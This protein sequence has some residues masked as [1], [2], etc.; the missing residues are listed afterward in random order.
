[1]SN[2]SFYKVIIFIIYL[3]IP[4]SGIAKDYSPVIIYYPRNEYH[5]KSQ[6]WSVVTDKK[7]NI[8]FGNNDGLLEFDGF[9]WKLHKYPNTVNTRSLYYDAETDRIYSGH[10]EEVGFWERD[11]YGNLSYNS[12]KEQFDQEFLTNNSFWS[13]T[14]QDSIVYFQSFAAI[15][16]YNESTK[17][18]KLLAQQG[19]FLFLGKANKKIYSKSSDLGLITIKNESFNRMGSVD[20]VSNSTLRFYLDHHDGTLIGSAENG[21]FILKDDKIKEW[22]AESN[23]LL[24]TQNINCGVKLNNGDYAIGSISGGLFILDK[25]G[26]IL[27]Q[28]NQHNGLE[29]N[30]VLSIA[31]DQQDNLWLGLD[32]GIAHIIVNS[33][34]HYRV[35]KKNIPYSIYSVIEHKG[36]CYLA[37]NTGLLFAKAKS[38]KHLNF[39][40]LKLMPGINEHI[41]KLDVIE[42]ELLCGCNN[43][44]Y[45]IRN[46]KAVS[47]S[48]KSGVTDFSLTWHN[49][50]KY[51]VASTYNDLYVFQLNNKEWEFAH[52]VKGF[53]GTCRLIEIDNYG[54]VW[55]SHEVKGLTRLKLD[56]SYSE[57]LSSKSFGTDDGLP[58]DYHLDIFNANQHIV[59]STDI[60]LYTFD[61]IQNKIV[62]FKKLNRILSSS[63]RINNIISEGNNHLWVVGDRQISLVQSD[64]DS[65]YIKRNY[66]IEEHFSLTDKFQSLTTG[67]SNTYFCLDNGFAMVNKDYQKNEVNDELFF[68]RI[69]IQQSPYKAPLLLPLQPNSKINLKKN[70]SNITFTFNTKFIKTY[71]PIFQYKLT[72]EQ[73]EWIDINQG[74][75]LSFQQLESGNYTLYLRFMN[76]AGKYSDE[77]S[78]KFTI[79]PLMLSYTYIPIGL[80]LIVLSITL[81]SIGTY[82]KRTSKIKVKHSKQ[83]QKKEQQVEVL[84]EEVKRKELENLENQLTISTNEI[85]KRDE[86]IGAIKKELTKAYTDLRGRFPQKNYKKILETIELQMIN[87]EKDRANFEQHFMASQNRF[88]DNLKRD[89]PKLTTTDLR[90]CA[91]LKMNLSSKEIA[92]Y[93]NI[94]HRSVEVSRYRLRK[95]LNL[96]TDT[97]LLHFLLKY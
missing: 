92:S 42:G 66:T 44:L 72:P 50:Q 56:K 70:R 27:Y 19:A 47:I 23:K 97:S 22:N 5:S 55:L 1:M 93:L 62:P 30:T 59:I 28:V 13:I 38:A 8:Y 35:D 86:A 37:T 89:F 96:D 84:K 90:L 14:K 33:P 73:N 10:Y 9:D 79:L 63:D 54:F 34:L 67:G 87:N 15:L 77:I 31:K 49:D 26:N 18:S 75:T 43:G 58:S 36:Y 16:T 20:S 52:S 25:N 32:N 81:I 74:N 17:T 64:I 80:L 11:I 76:E 94:A 85:L 4:I 65:L 2:T 3:L 71:K 45:A 95:K 57:I 88:Y 53:S 69:E 41:W 51:L 40:E 7:G 21:L 82:K 12:L 48:G 91:L 46:N 60:G 83:L 61:Y 29:N 68:T 24:K 39:S 78:Y 6:N